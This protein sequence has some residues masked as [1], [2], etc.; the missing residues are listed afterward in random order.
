MDEK[1]ATKKI[2]SVR[3]LEVYRIAFDT[4][5]EIFNISKGFPV[6][7]KYSLTDQIRRSSRAVCA[8]LAEGWRKRAYKAVFLNKLSDSA[9]E[10]SE[11]QTWLEFALKCG[12][13][14]N[15]VFDKLDEQY[16]HIFAMLNTM[17]RKADAFCKRPS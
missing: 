6:D 15:E 9:Q 17:A 14:G 5:M 3:E 13:I 4:A 12:Y 11:T 10:A 2:S 1:A 16:E 8:N 7:E